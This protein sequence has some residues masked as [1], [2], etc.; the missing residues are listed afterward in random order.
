[1]K[2]YSDTETV[3]VVVVGS[4]AG[5]APLAAELARH[6]KSVVVLEAGPAFSARNHTPDEITA[7][8]LYWLNERL[9]TGTHPQAFGGNNSGTG[10]GG[11]LLHYGAFMPRMDARDF[12]LHTETGKGV[13]WPFGLDELLPYIERVESFIGVSGPASYP[14]DANRRYAYPP[15]PANSAALKM[16]EGCDALSLKHADG[17]AALITRNTEQPWFGERAGCVNCG[18]CHQGCRNGAKSG[19]DNTWLPMAVAHGAE[20]RP[21][22]VVHGL[23]RDGTGRITAVIYHRDGQDHRQRC[24]TVVLAAGAVETP[25]L[26]LHTGLA[27]SSGQVG[28]NYMTHV[29]TQVWGVF[30]E[31]MRPNRGYPSLTITEDMVRPKDADFVGGYLIQSLGMMP[32]TW[33]L[34]LARSTTRR[35]HDLTQSL[36]MYNRSAGI[37]ING[38]CLPRP[39]N[40]VTLSDETDALGVPKPLISHS[41]GPNELAIHAHAANLLAR[42]WNAVGA[43][44]IRVIDRAAHMIGTC[45]MGTDGD[46][47]VVNSVGRSFDI[48]N[49]WIC[50][51]SI[52]PSAAAANPALAIMALS[53]RT[54]D[55]MLK[56]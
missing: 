51:H 52:F 36:A 38:E 24:E 50:D 23:E 33:A 49:L 18:A 1:M 54:A 43:Q 17:P 32:L 12:H 28:E 14:W 21:G 31:D 8:E 22:C 25:R 40:R 46:S 4:G 37:G 44:D 53:L 3:D 34:N 35:G 47:A 20:L 27:N 30:D 55:A 19:A 45:R 48:D 16:R 2:T 26:L 39:E 10:L 15:P 6:G 56:N 29:S 41:Y 13:D 9:S 11:S 7:R 42:L 5:G